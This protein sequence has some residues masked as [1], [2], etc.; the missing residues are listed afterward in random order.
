MIFNRKNANKL[1]KKFLSKYKNFDDYTNIISNTDK[2]ICIF[3]IKTDCD[4]CN[5]KYI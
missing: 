5:K 3:F 4:M 2:L 1:K